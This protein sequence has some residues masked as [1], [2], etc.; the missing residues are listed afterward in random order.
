MRLRAGAAIAV[1]QTDD[2]VQFGRGHFQ[3]IAFLY[4]SHT[5]LHPR[6]YMEA[7]AGDEPHGRS[8]L[9]GLQIHFENSGQQLNGLVL[10]T[11]IL[12]AQRFS[13]FN[14]KDFTDVPIRVSPYELM[15]PGFVDYSSF[16]G[17]GLHLSGRHYNRLPTERKRLR[18]R[19]CR[20]SPAHI[21][22]R[23]SIPKMSER[24][25]WIKLRSY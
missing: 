14:M 2:I 1:F 16:I 15:S 6:S 12:I 20:I 24:G 10:H 19:H 23:K 3:Y 9:V 7:I 21:G 18:R 13:L 25:E 4:R 8:S 22:E 17:N 5:M 11:M